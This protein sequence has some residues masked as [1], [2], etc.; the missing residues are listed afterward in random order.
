MTPSPASTRARL[1]DLALITYLGPIVQGRR[2]AV[3]G[4]ASGEVARRARVLGA[5]V[6]ISFGGVGDDIAVRALT[7]GALA[8]MHGRLDV[9]VV[10]DAG[11]VPSIVAVLDEARRALG[12]DGVVVVASQP[13]DGAAPLEP[14]AKTSLGFYDLEDLC[15]ARF[16]RVRMFGRGPFL[17]YTLA[18]LD[19]AGEDVALDTRLLDGDPPPPEAFVAV[20][21]DGEVELDPLAVVQLPPEGLQAVRA[22]A[23]RSLE[24]ELTRQ[25][26]KLKEV[27]A[28]SAERWV[29]IQRFE[30]GVK[31]LEEENR[32]SRDKAVRLSKELEDERKLRQR[33][34]LEAQ[35]VR[36]APELPKTPDLAPE[37]KRLEG[38]VA[39]LEGEVARVEREVAA[40]KAAEAAATTRATEAADALRAV[41]AERGIR[42]VAHAEETA[43]AA[44]TLAAAKAAEAAAR[45]RVDDLS[46]EL[47]ETQAA[48]AELR[49]Q[50]DEATERLERLERNDQ[51]PRIQALE[52]EVASLREGAVVDGEYARL[53]RALAERAAA[54]GKLQ[55]E[56][57]ALDQS[58]RELTLSLGAARSAPAEEELA[59]VRSRLAAAAS[60]HATLAEKA[61]ALAA[62]NDLLRERAARGVEESGAKARE[63]AEKADALSAEADEVRRQAA[64]ERAEIA[65]LHAHNIGLEAR[66]VHATMELEGAR[67]GYQRRVAELERESERLVRALEVS[68][69]QSDFDRA[70]T[71]EALERDVAAARAER[72][73]LAWRAK[74]AEAS[75]QALLAQIAALRQ[76]VVRLGARAA[77]LEARPTDV[78]ADD[79]TVLQSGARVDALVADLSA[80]AERLARTEEELARARA[81]A[82]KPGA[83]EAAEALRAELA[84]L[85]GERDRKAAD[86]EA[87]LGQLTDRDL[88]IAALER[89]RE[90]ELSA[91]QRSLTLESQANR[92]LRT[93]LDAVRS[94]LSAILVDGRGAMVAHDLMALLRRIED[95]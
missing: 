3:V 7:P 62:E 59:E 19:E 6:V 45:A 32:K 90:E 24:E 70:A 37:V 56:R 34:E 31:E 82:A 89:R 27:E 1:A 18:S 61:D 93:S 67:A 65:R 75:V 39:R 58:V 81:E 71:L 69:T 21:S 87:L 4:P 5:S 79:D 35:M 26:Q 28:A 57:D 83:A 38:E 9:V 16:A 49:G 86:V 52:A 92:T 42:E 20:A 50:L 63:L 47:D 95:A 54:L 22:A 10:P 46:R 11:A 33:V 2:V 76:E 72:D 80:T 17:G 94:G 78:L 23:T 29:K 12:S 84:E 25:G 44:R 74:E 73:G 53:E 66:V 68:A 55:A 40:A 51:T 15:A 60:V 13:E 48:E 30:H 91:V 8:G 64:A 77:E 41:E 14:G 36:R 85:S 88:R 43:E